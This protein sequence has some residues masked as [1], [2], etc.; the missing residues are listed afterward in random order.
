M[1]ALISRTHALSPLEVKLREFLRGKSRVSSALGSTL[2]GLD[3]WLIAIRAAAEPELPGLS[4]RF[5]S[6]KTGESLE[7]IALQ[8]IQNAPSLEKLL[9]SKSLQET[10]FYCLSCDT[11]LGPLQIRNRMRHFLSENDKS[12]VLQRFLTLFFFNFIW[13]HTGESFRT[14]AP[15]SSAFEEDME[16]VE[17]VCGRVVNSVWES[18]KLAEKPQEL[19]TARKLVRQIEQQLRGV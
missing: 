14:L 16:S 12:S 6:S 18:L 2:I 1:E 8:L 9:L 10:L 17:R 7:R 13:F 3:Q 19:P 4:T 5:K 15:T 11:D